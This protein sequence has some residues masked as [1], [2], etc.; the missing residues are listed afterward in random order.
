MMDRQNSEFKIGYQGKNVYPVGAVYTVV[1]YHPGLSGYYPTSAEGGK[2]EAA[3]KFCNTLLYMTGA[4]NHASWYRRVPDNDLPSARIH[5][6]ITHDAVRLEG[7]S[8]GISQ[9]MPEFILLSRVRNFPK[10]PEF[11]PEYFNTLIKF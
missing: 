3:G 10:C 6:Q 11:E 5:S 9:Y 1:G 8:S 7:G 4:H 2:R